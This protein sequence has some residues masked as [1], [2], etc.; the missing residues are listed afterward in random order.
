MNLT[1]FPRFEKPSGLLPVNGLTRLVLMWFFACML[2]APWA[3]GQQSRYSLTSWKVED[4]LPQGSVRSVTQTKDGYLWIA[5][6]NGLARFD[7]I[8]FTIFHSANT[9][10]LLSSIG[11]FAATNESYSIQL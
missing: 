1:H 11:S 5:T 7:G 9:P 10:A 6:W 2:A 8:K 4:G 3:S